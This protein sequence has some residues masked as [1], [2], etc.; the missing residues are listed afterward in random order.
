MK[1]SYSA[2]CAFIFVLPGFCLAGQDCFE[3]TSQTMPY[4]ARPNAHTFGTTACFDYGSD[5]SVVGMSYQ[6]YNSTNDPTR[7]HDLK[8]AYIPQDRIKD[9]YVLT[10]DGIEDKKMGLKHAYRTPFLLGGAD[11]DE[12]LFFL[13][14]IF[15]QIDPNNSANDEYVFTGKAEYGYVAAR[16]FNGQLIGISVKDNSGNWQYYTFDDLKQADYLPYAAFVRDLRSSGN[17][18]YY[19]QID[20][21]AAVAL[22]KRLNDAK[23]KKA[24]ASN[25]NRI[26]PQATQ[27]ASQ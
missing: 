17:G 20:A 15:Y 18:T 1:A 4:P 26:L 8:W 23:N 10:K 5:G 3:G 27:L 9:Q 12:G 25:V 19:S 6:Y 22:I 2:I 13:G 16:L 24:M 11:C 14:Y 21:G 7:W